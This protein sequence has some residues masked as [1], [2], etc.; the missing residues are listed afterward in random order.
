[1]GATEAAKRVGPSFLESRGI[2]MLVHAQAARHEEAQFYK[3]V[4]CPEDQ[5][6]NVQQRSPS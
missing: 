5:V 4:A 6:P 2:S 3:S 1:M